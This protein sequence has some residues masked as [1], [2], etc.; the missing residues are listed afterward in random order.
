MNS[1]I[2][3]R[4]AEFLSALFA[5][6][7]NF[8]WLVEQDQRILQISACTTK[9]NTSTGMKENKRIAVTHGRNTGNEFWGE[10]LP[11]Q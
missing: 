3:E 11:S 9:E 5:K 4:V 8:A 10:D 7:T 1:I 6:M 2:S